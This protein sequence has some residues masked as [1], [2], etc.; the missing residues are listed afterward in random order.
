MTYD[1]LHTTT[2]V[3]YPLHTASFLLAPQG[4][5][6]HV[7][8]LPSSW[9]PEEPAWRKAELQVRG[10]ARP[11]VPDGPHERLHQQE[12]YEEAHGEDAEDR[13]E[14]EEAEENNDG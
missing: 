1:P 13:A 9:H 10:G 14:N 3:M 2:L 7:Q 8:A 6:G 5:R 12:T 4:P 11:G